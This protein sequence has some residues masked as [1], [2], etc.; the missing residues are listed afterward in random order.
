MVNPLHRAATATT[1]GAD[2]ELINAPRIG[3]SI[4]AGGPLVRPAP[5]KD[6]EATGASPPP[7]PTDAA[8]D[9]ML[10]SGLLD[11]GT[12]QTQTGRVNIEEN[13]LSLSRGAS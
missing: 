2:R 12:G 4:R 5:F 3:P 9:P 10:P 11:M 1:E 13:P 8:R 6:V 7:P